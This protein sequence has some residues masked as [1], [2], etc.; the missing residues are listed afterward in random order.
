MFLPA[1]A[2]FVA[3]LIV[4]ASFISKIDIA[5]IIFCPVIVVV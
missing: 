2:D 4:V 1:C 5:D 3:S